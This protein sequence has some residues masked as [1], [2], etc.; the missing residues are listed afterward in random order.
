MGNS[1]SSIED[2]SSHHEGEKVQPPKKEPAKPKL[3]YVFDSNKDDE[4]PPRNTPL[5]LTKLMGNIVIGVFIVTW[6]SSILSPVLLGVAIYH[7]YNVIAAIIVGISIMAYLPWNRKNIPIC[8]YIRDNIIS[9]YHLRLYSSTRIIFIEKQD[10]QQQSKEDNNINQNPTFYGIH[11]HGAFCLGWSILFCHE[12][13]E[14]VKFCFAPILY[15]SPFFRL[16]SRIT[17]TP[18]SASKTSLMTYMKQHRTDIALPPGGFEEATLTSTSQ[19]RV[20]LHNRKGFIKLCLKYGYNIRPT[21]VFGEKY[22]YW[23]VQGYWKLRLLLNKYNIPTIF[24]WGKFFFPLL[25]KTNDNVHL[26]IVVGPTISVPVG[27]I[28]HP[29]KDDVH[30]YHTKYV[31][32][33]QNLFET[34]KDLAYDADPKYDSKTCKLEIW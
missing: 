32:A 25:P 1:T 6:I 30:V 2:Y 4:D 23:N 12:I 18:G 13:M 24:T 10:I 27:G 34:Y 17:G 14:N 3:V 7:E 29:T 33:I 22:T 26:T 28:E 9:Y 19:D 8:N 21:Y 11:P 16:F 15:Y 31:N 5:W 20:F